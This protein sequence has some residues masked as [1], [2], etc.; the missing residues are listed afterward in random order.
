MVLCQKGVDNL[1]YNL[2]TNTNTY[3]IEGFCY[4][5]KPIECKSFQTENDVIKYGGK[6]VKF[7]KNCQKRFD[8]QNKK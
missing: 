4:R 1:K 5:S 8:E 3:H 2:N 7:C 6:N